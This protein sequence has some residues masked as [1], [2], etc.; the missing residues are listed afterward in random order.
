MN[1]EI[2]VQ[3][4]RWFQKS[5]GNTYHKVYV[6][7]SVFA[8]SEIC[9]GY[10]DGWTMTLCDLL[11]SK[12]VIPQRTGNVAPLRWLHDHG[13]IIAGENISDVQRKKD[14]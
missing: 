2:Q 7:G 11:S 13:F 5:Y 6:T 3:V 1:N 12:G 14:L 8:E 4:N 10:G 9:Y